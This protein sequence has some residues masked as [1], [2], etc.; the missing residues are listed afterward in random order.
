MDK[1]T[2]RGYICCVTCCETSFIM[3][4][5]IVLREA[6]QAVWKEELAQG[7]DYH[8]EPEQAGWRWSELVS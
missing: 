1:D 4:G 5:S 8:V 7:S 6:V 2:G 3:Q